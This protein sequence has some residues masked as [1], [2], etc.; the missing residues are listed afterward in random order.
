MA[1]A[2]QAFENP[3]TGERIVF[4][5]TGYESNGTIL[6]IEFFIRPNIGRGLAAHF[7]PY[8][9]ERIEVIAGTAHYDL[10]SVEL[11]TQA[12]DLLMLPIS[13]PDI[14]PGNV[15]ND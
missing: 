13:I 3:V 7:H 2:G 8:F 15:F 9:D 10:G 14:H 4:G 6:E 11:P 5:K 12:A 1:K